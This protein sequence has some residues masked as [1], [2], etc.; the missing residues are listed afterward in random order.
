[1]IVKT[2]ETDTFGGQ[3]NYSWV[4]REELNLPDAATERQVIMAAKSAHGWTG[5][6]CRKE[7][8]GDSLALWPYGSCSVLFISC[9]V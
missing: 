4:R 9:H 6:R 5:T 7:P 8:L 3:P 2:E 1:M